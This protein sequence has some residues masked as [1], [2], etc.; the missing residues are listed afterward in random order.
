[1]YS[2]ACKV[3]P[4]AGKRNWKRGAL[5]VSQIQ[6]SGFRGVSH[7]SEGGN[8]MLTSFPISFPAVSR[9]AAMGGKRETKPMKQI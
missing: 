9:F 6:E 1:M 2:L 7:F 4:G 3:L 8:E 5:A